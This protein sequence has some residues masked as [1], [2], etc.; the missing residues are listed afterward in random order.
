MLN[1]KKKKKIVEIH[2]KEPITNSNQVLYVETRD[3]MADLGLNGE[4]SGGEV[5]AT[6][7]WLDNL[8]L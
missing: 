6:W 1:E 5:K 4:I 2:S 3:D 7:S 8:G